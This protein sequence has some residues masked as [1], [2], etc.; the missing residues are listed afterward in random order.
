MKRTAN[1]PLPAGR[2]SLAS[3][4][5][6]SG[7]LILLG[8][9]FLT[10]SEANAGLLALLG[11]FAVIWYNGIY[12]YLKRLTAFAVI[13]G[14]LLGALPPVI[15]WTAAGGDPFDPFGIDRQLCLFV[16]Y[17]NRNH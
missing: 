17:V 10:S 6:L 5:F 4:L 15:G 9:Y 8:L 11:A 13:P 2:M 1:R 3:A 7:L 14:A 12:T 16:C